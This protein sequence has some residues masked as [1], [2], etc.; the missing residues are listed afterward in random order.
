MYKELDH[1]LERFPQHRGRII[2]LYDRNEDF[3]SLCNDYLQCKLTME[4]FE[5]DVRHGIRMENQYRVL[6]LDLEREV[7]HFLNTSKK[8]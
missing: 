2:E 5:K 8:I 3:R 7:L 6:N 1:M 4:K